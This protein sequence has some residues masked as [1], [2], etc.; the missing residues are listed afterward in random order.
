MDHDRRR[1]AA[2]QNVVA[3]FRLVRDHYADPRGGGA[4]FG[5]VE[6]IA[7][8]VESAFF[9]MALV[10]DPAA[11]PGDVVAAADWIE[12]RGLP[13]SIHVRDDVGPDIA[14]ALRESGFQAEAWSSPVMVLEPLPPAPIP[15]LDGV[16][17]RVGGPELHDDFHAALESGDAFRRVL[18]TAFLSDRSVRIATAYL[19]G[20]P[21]SAAVA[22]R[23]GLAAGIYVVWTQ[24]RARRR[25]IGRAVTWAAIEAARRTWNVRIAILQSSEMGLPVY[26]SMGFAEVSRYSVYLR[27][28]AVPLNSDSDA[29]TDP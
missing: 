20:E 6:A 24:E 1:Q 2:D 27:P 22:I 23:S 3:A 21:V 12:G 18:G 8:G 25:G 7:T 26:R 19:L 10:L 17:L 16:T 9:N 11:I 13:A 15:D 29:L 4:R 28:Q 14:T 5:R